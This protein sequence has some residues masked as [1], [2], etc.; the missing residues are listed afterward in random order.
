[1]KAFTVVVAWLLLGSMAGLHAEV[2]QPQQEQPAPPVRG[3]RD[4]PPAPPDPIE[5][6]ELEQFREFQQFRYA[7]PVVRFGI[8]FVLGA[9]GQVGDVT[10]IMS[11]ATIEGRV[12]GDVAVILG[13]LRLGTAAVVE[14]SVVVVGGSVDVSQGAVIRDDF[15]I[16]AGG[17]DAPQGFMPGGEHVLIGPPVIGDGLRSIGPWFTHGLLWGRVIVPSLPWV[18]GIVGI[19]LLISVALA[20]AFPAAVRSCTEALSRRP[21]GSFFAGLFALLLIGPISTILAI[22]V[23]GII[24]IPFLI[25]AAVVGWVLGKV[26]VA[27]WIGAG[28]M[29]QESMEDRAQSIRS[30][31]IGFAV[32]CLAYMVPILGLATWALV[33]VLGLGA[34]TL[35]AMSGLKHE[36][37]ARAPKAEAPPAAPIAPPPTVPPPV[38]PSPMASA[39]LPDAPSPQ[40]T[41]PFELSAEPAVP[42][43]PDRS[44]DLLS[45]PRA[46]F[47]DRL[48]AFV[49]DLVL[50]LIAY[51]LLS[52][53]EDEGVF[54]VLLLGYHI[55][56]WAWKGT[57]VG[58]IV[59]NLRLIRTDGAPL[60]PADALVRGLSSLFSIA[61]LGIGFLW[62]LRDP[63][64]QAWH[65]KIAGTYVVSVPRHWP[66][67]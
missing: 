10:V 14:G 62:I 57:T 64:R 3:G 22:S 18:W 55:A 6:P 24:V 58:G 16:V 13:G 66:L 48:A 2:S 63:E 61:A 52:W 40:V 33:G 4:A 67:P 1:M 32:I 25:G 29:R 7:R 5:R 39:A 51:N 50:V 54:F 59:C 9:G 35:S 11:D 8:P 12:E 36:R 19:S 45:F 44:A 30:V 21:I 31:L 37:P 15:V 41:S 49:L 26:G 53:R 56:F 43:A 46:S 47:L 17:L 65:D 42:P 28:I 60:R 23:V 38:A 27:R 34:A 20:V